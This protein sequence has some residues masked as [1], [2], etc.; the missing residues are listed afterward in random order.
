MSD[1][2]FNHSLRTFRRVLAK[3]K[4]PKDPNA[5]I[6][7][8]KNYFSNIKPDQ[9]SHLF[10]EIS[11]LFTAI[12]YFEPVNH[13]VAKILQD[14]VFKN[15]DILPKDSLVTCAE[16]C[17]LIKFRTSSDFGANET[18]TTKTSEIEQYCIEHI[19]K[20]ATAIDIKFI[21]NILL[22]KVKQ[23][24]L[25]S[26][27]DF[28]QQVVEN[29]DAYRKFRELNNAQVNTPKLSIGDK[30]NE[31][32]KSLRKSDSKKRA[33]LTPKQKQTKTL[34]ESPTKKAKI[35]S[36]EARLSKILPQN[37][38]LDDWNCI[39]LVKKINSKN[40]EILA[41]LVKNGA[42]FTDGS[43]QENFNNEI[44]HLFLDQKSKDNEGMWN[45]VEAIKGVENLSVNCEFVFL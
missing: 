23:K 39:W 42:N 24:N 1:E 31:L 7:T 30:L 45:N 19:V 12:L 35:D 3:I 43:D 22:G 33:P 20:K 21:E 10:N 40:T 8:A 11:Y 36:V 25:F 4:E 15:K 27:K 5:R 2:T 13:K 18:K 6:I 41:N 34:S 26:L 16:V 28:L 14:Q 9:N 32:E 37:D 44:T 29:R 17:N 38:T